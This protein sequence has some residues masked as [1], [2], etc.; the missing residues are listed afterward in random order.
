M[1]KESYS[2]DGF[3]GIFENYFD[4]QYI[5][6]LIRYYQTIND[7]NLWQG[8]A[9]PKHIRDDEQ[10]YFLDPNRIHDVHPHFVNYFFHVIWEKIFPIYSKEFSILCEKKLKGDQ[11][12][13]KRIA[14]GAGFHQWHYE[15]LGVHSNRKLVI[16]LYMNDIDEA[17]E[18]EFLYQNKRISPKR[19]RLLVWPSDWTHT[20]RGNPPIGKTDKYILTTWLMEE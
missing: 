9:Q 16:Q 15:S 2:F 4:E 18:T 3:I 11:V 20:H 13:M 8:K 7:L 14:P 12:K 17:G 1:Q 10:L 19:N 6:E 5:S